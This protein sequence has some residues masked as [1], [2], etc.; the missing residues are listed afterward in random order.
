MGYRDLLQEALDADEG[1]G[2]LC[3]GDDGA[4]RLR[5]QLYMERLDARKEGILDFDGLS[6][7]IS[8]SAHNILF[9]YH[10]GKSDGQ[11]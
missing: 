10:R 3:W 4:D 8:P 9:I 2:V 11:G 7:S 5:R 6:L 1:I